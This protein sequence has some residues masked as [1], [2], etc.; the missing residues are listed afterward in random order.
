MKKKGQLVAI[1]F[2]LEL[3]IKMWNE[4]RSAKSIA[5]YFGVTKNVIIG[6]VHRARYKGMHVVQKANPSKP[7]KRVLTPPKPKF[8][9]MPE[10]MQVKDGLR[11]YN[12]ESDQCKYSI[13]E[14]ESGEYLFCGKLHTNI[15]YCDEHH[16]LC[17]NRPEKKEQISRRDYKNKYLRVW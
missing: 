1:E 12:L 13:G 8:I 16:K 10:E 4:G 6:R 14:S 5:G 17:H 15:A 2:D 7:R 11:I 9:I 3:A